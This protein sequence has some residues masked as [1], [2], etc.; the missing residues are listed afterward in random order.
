ML[1]DAP[2]I[3]CDLVDLSPESVD[4]VSDKLEWWELTRLILLAERGFTNWSGCL[5]SGRCITGAGPAISKFRHT[6]N[7]YLQRCTRVPFVSEY[8]EP[9]SL[10]PFSRKGHGAP[11][12]G[13]T[14][15]YASMCMYESNI[16]LKISQWS[17]ARG[18]EIF[19]WLM[20]TSHITNQPWLASRNSEGIIY[21]SVSEQSRL[22]LL[23]RENP[24][25]QIAKNE[26]AR[27][28]KLAHSTEP[29]R[30]CKQ[31][32]LTWHYRQPWSLL[33]MKP[34]KVW[35]LQ[36]SNISFTPFRM[37]RSKNSIVHF[38]C[39]CINIHQIYSWCQLF[40]FS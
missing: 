28:L 11:S 13:N 32:P 22:N 21:N 37:G 10:Q 1:L 8:Q 33:G 12:A 3:R 16:S 14:D 36:N 23:P 19:H 31:F 39:F 34:W 17:D 38:T 30:K 35:K 20:K 25:R 4:A 29:A 24:C 2:R 18:Q 40:L 15:H 7:S 27:E 9:F 5:R 6:C 26:P